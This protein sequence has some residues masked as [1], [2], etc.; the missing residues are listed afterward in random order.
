METYAHIACLCTGR[1]GY[2]IAHVL[3]AIAHN[4]PG[5][6]FIYQEDGIMSR[7]LCEHKMRTRRL[8]S[9]VYYRIQP[10]QS[11]VSGLFKYCTLYFR[12]RK[13]AEDLKA[14]LD[15]EKINVIHTHCLPNH[16]MASL[17]P[18]RHYRKIWHVHSVINE[19][20]LWGLTKVI[21][22]MAVDRGATDLICVSQYAMR[23]FNVKKAKKHVLCNGIE[24]V[25]SSPLNRDFKP[26]FHLIAVGRMVRY[27][28][29]HLCLAALAAI[30]KQGID[31]HLHIYGGPLER[32]PYYQELMNLSKTL[33]ITSD[34]TFYGY[35]DDIRQR[36][37]D[38]H[39]ALH[40]HTEIE[41]CGIWV[42]EAMLD[43]LPVVATRCGGPEELIDDGQNGI[44]VSK[45][46]TDDQSQAI[47][48][49]LTD[50][51]LYRRMS[52]SA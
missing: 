6:L 51:T 49:L 2:G 47:T 9:M 41:P 8:E 39:L 17:L 45:A 43:G 35:V 42:E 33:E 18:K 24:Q 38:M 10:G 7:W 31:A 1:E 40:L 27:K 13:A 5:M 22:S 48:R 16:L 46:D 25:Y 32:N 15:A 44:F 20:R 26:P 28:G 50:E 23:K 3:K 14:I 30:R 34:V 36:T 37:R 21:Y 29:F 52:Q 11:T 12:M 4:F 19:K